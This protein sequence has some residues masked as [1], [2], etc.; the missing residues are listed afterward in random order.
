MKV[1]ISIVVENT[2]P[3]PNLIGE[4]GFSCL[5]RVDDNSILFDTG[6]HQA[7]FPNCKALGIK[8][9][10][11]R[12]VVISHGHYDHTGAILPLLENY[13]PK[14]IYAH[15]RL[16]LPRL[17]PRGNGGFRNIGSPFSREQLEKAGAKFIFR[18]SFSQI[19]PGVY[20]SGEIPRIFDF[21]N[22]G[23][24]FKY[25]ADGEIKDDSLQDDM[26]LIIDHPRGLIIVS[27]CAHA[28]LLN[29]I[30]HAIRMTGKTEV[31]A[32][33]GGTHL[34]S[35]SAERLD[36][37]VAALKTYSIEKFIVAH[38]TGFTAAARLYNELGDM[39][40]KGDTGMNFK[41]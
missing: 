31:L 18:D 35:A 24:E 7:L 28:G 13:G 1:S 26:A 41:F 32:Y 34:I 10:E 16:F 36:R 4:Y 38:C 9:G 23:G 25:E 2:T 20:L 5:V 39:V 6:S 37:T 17:Y 8:L 22:V 27:G 11:I 33:I 12:N 40:V 3:A 19:V 29:T 30:D 21:E 14:D 15:S